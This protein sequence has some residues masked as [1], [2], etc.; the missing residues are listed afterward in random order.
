MQSPSTIAVGG[1]LLFHT[2]YPMLNSTK[3]SGSLKVAVSLQNDVESFGRVL[4]YAVSVFLVIIAVSPSD[5]QNRLRI[6]IVPVE[7]MIP[8]EHLPY[9]VI[10]LPQS[11]AVS[12]RFIPFSPVGLVADIDPVH[13]DRLNLMKTG[14]PNQL[15]HALAFDAVA[16]IHRIEE[17]VLVQIRL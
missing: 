11:V 14:F 9:G 7:D 10:S 13:A 8:T 5:I 3:F 6:G 4:V 16:Q 12:S 2:A 17:D 1:L 15:I